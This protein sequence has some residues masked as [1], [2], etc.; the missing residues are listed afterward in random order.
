M[1]SAH[2]I[3]TDDRPDLARQAGDMIRK[4][5]YFG[6]P[7]L[8][9]DFEFCTNTAVY[10]LIDENEKLVGA[11]SAE[12]TFE[13]GADLKGTIVNDLVIEKDYRGKGLGRLILERIAADSF[14]KENL[15]I[16]VFPVTDSIPF[17]QKLGFVS[18]S[19]NKEF[20][21]APTRQ[22]LTQY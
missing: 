22:L 6:V 18:F 20:M 15:S 7:F 17:Y 19:A 11:A 5:L 3:D 16:V 4:D 10:A 9:P 14:A 21:I 1:Y 13:L 12:H 8:D 2:L